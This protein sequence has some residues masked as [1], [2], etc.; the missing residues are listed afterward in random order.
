MSGYRPL[1]ALPLMGRTGRPASFVGPSAFFGIVAA[2]LCLGA[3]PAQQP[4]ASSP[5]SAENWTVT[6]GKSLMVDS[7]LPVKRISVAD[8]ALADAVAVAPKEVLINGKAP[9]ET[10]V[11]V[12]QENG[13]RL[14]YNLTVRVSPARVDAIR[15]QIAL[16]FPEDDITIAS[17]NNGAVFVRGTVKDVTDAARVAAIA[18]TLGKVVNLLH[19]EVP[20]VEAQIAVKVRFCN[21]DRTVSRS[22]SLDLASG[23]LNQT[24]AIGVDQ[25]ISTNGAQTFSLSEAVN[26]FLFRHDLNLGVALQALASKNLLEMLAEPTVPAINGKAASFV[27]GGEF[28]FP[29]VQPGSNGSSSVIT[30]AWREYGIRLNFLPLITPRGT[31]RLHVA[32]EVSSLDYTH[33]VSVGGTTVPALSTRKVQTEIELESGQSFVIA[34]LLDNQTTENLSKVPGIGDIPIIGKLFQSKTISRSNSELLVIVTPEIVRP[35]PAGQPAPDLNFPQT[36]LPDNT[37]TPLRH[38]GMDKTGPVPVTPL[39]KTVPLEQLLQP[40]K[41]EYAAP[42]ATPAAN[43]PAPS[44]SQ[45][46]PSA[47]DAGE[48]QK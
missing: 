47:P 4:S 27:A 39:S 41:Q 31:I 28:P 3:L 22:L 45:A 48:I 2:V 25:P 37:T 32:P 5:D 43:A 15:Q 10:S 13:A 29:V 33:A 40:E 16:E 34:G 38:P 35:I 1:R 19:V 18:A 11:I 8:G 42:A 14:I 30:I 36:F 17:D 6:V 26:I 46:A 20:P 23:A 12:W 21:V 7:P 24:T 9:G 44:T